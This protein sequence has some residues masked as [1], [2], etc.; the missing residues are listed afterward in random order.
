[1]PSSGS[2]DSRSLRVGTIALLAI[3][4]AC[5]PS[6]PKDLYPLRA[7][8]TGLTGRGLVLAVNASSVEVHGP[9]TVELLR[10]VAGAYFDVRVNAQPAGQRCGVTGT[11][12][13]M[14]SDGATVEVDC[15]DT[16]GVTG[17]VQGLEGRGLELALT[18]SG[19]VE[20]LT[21]DPGAPDFAFGLQAA[22]GESYGVEIT[23]SPSNPAQ[24]CSIDAGAVGRLGP[25]GAQVHVTCASRTFAIAGSVSGLTG[26]GLALQLNGAEELPVAAGATSFQFPALPDT[27][28]Y[29][30][31]VLRQP[32][33]QRCDVANGKGTLAGADATGVAVRCVD[34]H[35]VVGHVSGLAGRGL[36]VRVQISAAAEV[37]AVDPA[38]PDFAST[39]RGL[40]GEP[41]EVAVVG[42]PSGPVQR[43]DVTAGAGG[44]IGAAD[45]QAEVACTTQPFTVGG[46]V[47]GLKGSGLALQLNGAGE[48]AVPVGASAFTFPSLPDG[49]PYEVKVL[50]QPATQRCEVTGGK[51]TLA[52]ADVT[53]VAVGCVDTHAVAVHVNGLAG[54]G[55]TV[56]VQI[57]GASEVLPVAP[58]SPD[59]TSTLRGVSGEQFAVGVVGSPSGPIQRCG[60]SAGAGGA[61]GDADAQAQ[62]ACET[63][64]FTVGGT[65][66]G[67]QGSGLAL[68]LNGA[69]ELAVPVGATRF[70]FPAIPDGSAY[71]VRVLRQ[72]VNQQCDVGNARGTLAGADVTTVAVA[73]RTIQYTLSGTVTGLV[74]DG[75]V[76]G[77]RSADGPTVTVPRGAGSFSFGALDVGTAYEVTVRTPPGAPQE[78]CTVVGGTGTLQASVVNVTIAC[79]A[80][81]SMVALGEDH[82]MAISRDGTLFGWGLNVDGQ[83]GGAAGITCARPVQVGTGAW[84][85][86]SAAGSQTAAIRPDG[87][88]WTWGVGT[89]GRLG[90]GDTTSRSV[91]TQVLPGTTWLAVAVGY[92]YMVAI[93]SDGTLWAWGS[94]DRGQL[95]DGSSTSGHPSPAQVGTDSDWAQVFTLFQATIA[96]KRDGAR[97]GCGYNYHGELGDGA[98]DTPVTALR[99]LGTDTDLVLMSGKGSSALALRSGGTLWGWGYNGGSELGRPATP[100]EP[101]PV[102]IGSDKTWAMAAAGFSYGLAIATDGSLWGWGTDNYGTLG[103]GYTTSTTVAAPLHVAADKS[104]SYVAAGIHHS[105]AIASDGR[106]WTWGYNM[107]GDLGNGMSGNNS[108]SSVPVPI[109]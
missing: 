84:R 22:E 52:G 66:S 40:A 92:R 42:A 38:S 20:K 39:A 81:W 28:A 25:A 61:I 57:S 48:L 45:A 83:V 6:R 10:Y 4:L 36:M 43:C 51:G 65:V 46:T 19:A 29:E 63:V 87:T 15:A 86:V 70:T 62:V 33:G 73:C 80:V 26:A 88:L 30:V 34:T 54:R 109:W 3:A 99:R 9:G 95:G 76:L 1:M 74:G 37:L 93:R 5:S 82:T 79:H 17:R 71:E 23:A 12:G 102:Q 27:A 50:R 98:V 35:A 7:H 69:G 60:V 105:A 18:L 11:P 31:K 85:S 14:S 97:W 94:N 2:V 8:V 72:P 68:Q 41:Y 108:N 104:W 67:L 78:T 49:S 89:D 90:L 96:I 58:A 100:R 21:V 106:L 91:P 59:L 16:H 32:A 107:Y 13:Y 64:P 24:R 55:L 56:R 101:S 44:T 77:L 47:S 53:A 103:N 75:M